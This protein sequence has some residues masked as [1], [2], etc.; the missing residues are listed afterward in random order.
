MMGDGSGGGPGGKL[1]EEGNGWMMGGGIF[2]PGQQL[3]DR[4]PVFHTSQQM[5][6]EGVRTACAINPPRDEYEHEYLGGSDVIP[7]II[8]VASQAFFS[9]GMVLLWSSRSAYEVDKGKTICA[10]ISIIPRVFTALPSHSD[11]YR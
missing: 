11:L 8:S 1:W 9:P 3:R 10:I 4:E 2:P 6:E 7:M 5:K